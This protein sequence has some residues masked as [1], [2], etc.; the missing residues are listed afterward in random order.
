VQLDD[1]PA[2]FDEVAEEGGSG[3]N[4]WYRVKLREG[5]N[6]EVRRLW[7][8]VGCNV[9]RLIRIG[10]GPIE[11]PRSMRRGAVR[12]LDAAQY[13]ALYDAAGLTPPAT[14]PPSRAGRARRQNRS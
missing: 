6:R 9:S 10:F 1:G 4:R 13:S 12:E 7:E 11:L 8:A 14:Q 3:T 2:R 5:R